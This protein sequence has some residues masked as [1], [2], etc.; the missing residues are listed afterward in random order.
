MNKS[1]QQK[2]NEKPVPGKE[3]AKSAKP[4]TKEEKNKPEKKEKS[5]DEDELKIKRP[6]SSY[7]QFMAEMRP[8]YKKDNPDLKG[9]ELNKVSFKLKNQGTGKNLGRNGRRS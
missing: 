3:I 1:V 8:K 9:P 7:F 6:S 4:I 2:K 5:K